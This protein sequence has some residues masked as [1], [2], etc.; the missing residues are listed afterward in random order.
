MFFLKVT[1]IVLLRKAHP[2]PKCKCTF[3]YSM[4]NAALNTAT[5]LQSAI[6]QQLCHV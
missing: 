2:N 6:V 4:H 1:T 5:L 3:V